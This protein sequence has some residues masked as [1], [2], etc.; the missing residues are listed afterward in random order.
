MEVCLSI[1]E[2]VIRHVSNTVESVQC[3]YF[4]RGYVEQIAAEKEIAQQRTENQI[5]DLLGR[6]AARNASRSYEIDQHSREAEFDRTHLRLNR[7]ED[8][9]SSVDD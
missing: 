5:A 7:E 9:F 2:S 8:S 1:L 4:N 6:I 3:T